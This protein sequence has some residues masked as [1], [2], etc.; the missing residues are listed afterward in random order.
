[1]EWKDVGNA[2]SGSAPILA[3]ILAS[4]ISAAAHGAAAL[5]ASSLGVGDEPDQVMQAIRSDRDAPARLQ[6]LESG[7][8]AELVRWQTAQVEAEAQERANA[9]QSSLEGDDRARLYWLTIFLVAVIFAFH[10]AVFF[11]GVGAG[12]DNGMVDRL[13]GSMGTLLGIIIAFWFGASRS[14]QNSERLLYNSR[15]TAAESH[16][17][18]RGK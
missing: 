12:I 3:G 16:G 10:Y 6:E 17:R 5:I 2:I 15:P 9:A 4:P 1:M 7:H 11:W 8:L 13:L 14:S 18:G